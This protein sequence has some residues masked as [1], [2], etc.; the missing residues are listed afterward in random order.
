MKLKLI[1][2]DPEECKE[3]S[4]LL[5]SIGHKVDSESIR[6]K[7]SFKRIKQSPPDVFIIDLSK[8]P[9]H[10]REVAVG[11]RHIKSTRNVPIVFTGGDPEKVE[12]IKLVMPDG[13]YTS[14]SKINTALNKAAKQL[15][16]EKTVPVSMMDRYVNSPL[17]KKLGIKENCKVSL[18]GAP[19]DFK[20]ILGDIP[21][22]VKF[23]NLLKEGSD[24]IIWFVRS[25]EEFDIKFFEILKS[26]EKNKL[27]VATQKKSSGIVTDI[28]QN[29]VRQI[30]LNEG[31]VD[32]KVCSIDKTWSGLLLNRRK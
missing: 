26:I 17:T 24:L 12:K 4:T 10:G 8:L 31:L 19:K 25:R 18:I 15:T 2:W 30:C 32:Y 11:L 16:T 13:I 21:P 6:D 9:S 7:E 27:W 20:K 29:I 3:K 14:W 5:K 28:N 22:N 23:Y 1:H